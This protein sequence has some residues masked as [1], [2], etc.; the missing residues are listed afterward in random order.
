LVDRRHCLGQQEGTGDADEGSAVPHLEEKDLWKTCTCT[1]RDMTP[2]L[3]TT[4]ST[5]SGV[6]W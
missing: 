3:C 4:N 1:P 5:P 2:E 6:E